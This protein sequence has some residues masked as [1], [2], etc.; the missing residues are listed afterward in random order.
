MGSLLPARAPVSNS[1]QARLGRSASLAD[2]ACC[3][4]HSL[5]PMP[6]LSPSQDAAIPVLTRPPAVTQ[7]TL[8]EGESFGEEEQRRKTLAGADMRC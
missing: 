2:L 4:P 3:N 8:D 6:F 1:P 7:H 5:H